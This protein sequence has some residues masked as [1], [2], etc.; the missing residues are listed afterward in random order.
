MLHALTSGC[1]GKQPTVN[2]RPD[3]RVPR[4]CPAAVAALYKQCTA[5]DP[6]ARPTAAQVVER[7]EAMQDDSDGSIGK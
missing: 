3:L 4:D 6:E 1:A 5:S 2:G 7:L